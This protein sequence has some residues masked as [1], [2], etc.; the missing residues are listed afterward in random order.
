MTVPNEVLPDL[1]ILGGRLT[2]WT[3]EFRFVSATPLPSWAAEEEVEATPS[4]LEASVKTAVKN[5]CQP[6]NYSLGAARTP[7]SPHTTNPL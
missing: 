2:A 1:R 6:R 4:K 5:C 7:H 3:A